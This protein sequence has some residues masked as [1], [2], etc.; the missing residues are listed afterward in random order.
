MK[1]KPTPLGLLTLAVTTALLVTACTSNPATMK[2][3]DARSRLT[4]LQA[5][6]QLASRAPAA[7]LEAEGA[8]RAAEADRK[9]DEQGRHLAVMA[10]RKVDIAWA[11]AQSKLLEDQRVALSEE[12]DRARLNART[13]EAND[14]RSEADLARN[15][16]DRARSDASVARKDAAIA[17][18]AASVARSDAD[19]A[20]ADADQAREET[21]DLQRLLAE[22]NARP[23]ERGMVVALG[24]VLFESGRAA[25]RS[26]ATN[27]LSKLAVYLSAN[28]DRAVYIEGHTDSLGSEASNMTLS[29]LR[30]DS[31]RAYLVGHGANAG[32]LAAAGMGEGTPIGDNATVAGREQNRRVEVIIA[33]PTIASR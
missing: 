6:S 17:I 11:Q 25:L 21:D 16:A 33:N 20:R 15:D 9:G 13:R 10:G 29:Q 27:N 14:A 23:T 26:G 22:L 1:L 28:Q 18:G 24:D 8:V 4:Q 5:D 31:V 3:T 7:I 30:A 19:A 32:R 2:V 12:R